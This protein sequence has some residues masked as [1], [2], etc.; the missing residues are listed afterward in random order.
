M[1]KAHTASMVEK[2][3]IFQVVQAIAGEQA[4][5][6][7]QAF[8]MHQQA[9]AMHQQVFAMH[10]QAFFLRQ[11]QTFFARYCPPAQPK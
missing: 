2:S 5:V 6:Q 8:A 11:P 7:Q 10:Q 3:G 9:F 1:L 4:L